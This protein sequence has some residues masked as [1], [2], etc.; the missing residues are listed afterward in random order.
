MEFFFSY[1]LLNFSIGGLPS[2]FIQKLNAIY[3]KNQFIFKFSCIETTMPI[4][5]HIFW[6]TLVVIRY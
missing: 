1:N 4:F 2:K 6:K 3:S 5:I